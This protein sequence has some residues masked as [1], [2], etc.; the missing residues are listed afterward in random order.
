MTPGDVDGDGALD[1]VSGYGE[2]TVLLNRDGP[3]HDLGHALDGAHGK[4]KQV[5]TGT[6]QPGTSVTVAL[7]DAARLSPA[8][9]FLGFGESNVPFKGGV[10][11]PTP[12]LVNHALKTDAHGDLVIEMLWPAGFVSGTSLVLQTW[13]RDD[14][15]P[16][17][18]SASNALR[19]T[20]P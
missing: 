16:A 10:L 7:H 17:L 1:L 15:A 18:W 4:P 6:A 13:I 5:G 19:V 3:W 12:D 2:L 11:V 20:T 9:Q 8:V 14:A